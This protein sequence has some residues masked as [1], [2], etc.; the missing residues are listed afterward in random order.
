VATGI[1]DQRVGTM[2]SD[3]KPAAAG[4]SKI[5]ELEPSVPEQGGPVDEPR[6]RPV[7]E[8]PVG[9]AP[10]RPVGEEPELPGDGKPDKPS[11]P[12]KPVD[13]TDRWEKFA[14]VP[15][16]PPGRLRRLGGRAGHVL[17]HEWTVVSLL[18]LILAVAMTWPAALR[19]ADTLPADLGDPALTAWTLAWPG[20]ALTGDPTKLL[21]ANA[22]FPE[23]FS[24]A[25]AE[26][27][28]GYAPL[29]LLGS[30]MTAAIVRYNVL[31]ILAFALA[32]IGAYALVRQLGATRIAAAVAGVAF[33]YAPWRA[34]QA[35]HLHVLASGGAVL[36]LAMLARGH[37]L[38]LRDGYR[39]ERTRVGWVVAGW[40]VAGWQ[41]SVGLGIGVVFGYLLAAGVLVGL[42]AVLLRRWRLPV[43]ILLTDLI[44]GLVFAGVAAAV[45]YPYLRVLK[46]HPDAPRTVEAVAAL[47]PPWRGLLVAPA[48]SLLWGA[49]H[50]GVR[51]SLAYPPE[52]TLL[53]GFTLLGLA[54]AGLFFSAWSVRVRILLALGVAVSAIAALGTNGPWH[55]RAGYRLLY[56]LP[57][58][59]IIRT[60]GRLIAWTI[61]LLAILAAGA[62]TGFARRGA[63]VRGDRV[64]GRP[65]LALRLVLLI[66]L[67]LV[68]VE[69]INTLPHPVVPKAPVGLAKL[70]EPIL[71]LPTDP[72]SDEL[73]MLWS[74]DGFPALVNGT[75][76]YRPPAQQELLTA[77]AA[78]P[79]AGS[80]EQLRAAGVRTVVI[81]GATAP[82]AADPGTIDPD[83][84]FGG[85]GSGAE[86]GLSFEQRPGML[87]YTIEP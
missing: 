34:S 15:V 76:A 65:E 66:P 49:L 18:G 37:G 8:Q 6:D 63:E 40:L 67:A 12:D 16:R 80:V 9:E 38:S 28:L 85:T 32:S 62:L 82:P 83:D 24:F 7:G 81:L 87:V 64:P 51:E 77:G 27:L 78:F 20:Q 22:F 45:A 47:S 59:D 86:P 70:P 74:T 33:A 10:D 19:P 55:G 50:A 23:R 53:P 71:V 17:T 72:V 58:F 4:G 61:L 11:D 84:P 60:S 35:G 75:G 39:R 1:D 73:Y 13:E 25:F 36:A 52:M 30:G 2:S 68:I 69:G 14:P 31:F 5:E 48:D 44:G 29:S 3:R 56:E 79:S 57:G 46:L 42:V 43:R 21:H 26:T 54:V 41:L